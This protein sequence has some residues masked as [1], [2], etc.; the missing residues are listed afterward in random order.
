MKIWILLFLIM[1]AI[2][3]YRD[4]KIPNKLNGAGALITLV[5][6]G[7]SGMKA[8]DMMIG[9]LVVLISCGLLFYIGCLGGGD[10]KL[11]MVCAISIG[12]AM[13]RFLILSFICNGIY[14]VIFLWKRKNFHLRLFRLFQY[15]TQCKDNKR[16]LMYETENGDLMKD[17]MIHFSFGILAAY[18]ICLLGAPHAPDAYPA[19]RPWQCHCLPPPHQYPWK[20]VA[21]KYHVHIH[22]LRNIPIPIHQPFRISA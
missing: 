13:P 10:V 14:A 4:F 8:A 3:D 1:A 12:R 2:Y 9:V 22:R 5:L 18:M 19:P 17:G 20:D 16:L 11:L 15:V 6:A 7:V 21:G